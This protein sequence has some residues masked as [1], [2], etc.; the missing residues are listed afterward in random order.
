MHAIFVW[1]NH[2]C[3][4][5][6]IKVRT[7][8]T[9]KSFATAWMILH[10]NPCLPC[11]TYTCS[12]ARISIVIKKCEN[13]N[14]IRNRAGLLKYKEI[15]WC[16]L[17]QLVLLTPPTKTQRSV[18]GLRRRPE[19]SNAFSQLWHKLQTLHHSFSHARAHNA[20]FCFSDSRRG[21]TPP[22]VARYRRKKTIVMCLCQSKVVIYALL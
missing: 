12:L 18:C 8:Q 13:L 7:R 5:N 4:E 3:S 14:G 10:L 16:L 11:V 19:G 2:Y 15:L 17:Y 20:A 21:S 1:Q 6:R 22:T 9:K